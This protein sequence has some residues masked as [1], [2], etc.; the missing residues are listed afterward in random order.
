ME[1]SLH[2]S[3][4]FSFNQMARGESGLVKTPPGYRPLDLVQ[5]EIVTVVGFH[6]LG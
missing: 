3:I 2:L 1:E 4:F 5:D 6:F